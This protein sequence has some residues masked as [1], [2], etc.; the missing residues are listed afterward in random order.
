LVPALAGLEKFH[1]S[2]K[3]FSPAYRVGNLKPPSV[4]TSGFNAASLNIPQVV[5]NGQYQINQAIISYLS[6]CVHNKIV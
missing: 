5:N 2:N 4:V 1:C 3:P 6:G